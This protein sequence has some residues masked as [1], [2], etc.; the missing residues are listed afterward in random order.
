MKSF[1]MRALLVSTLIIAATGC[2]KDKGGK[3]S[4]ANPGIYP[5]S[6]NLPQTDAE[7]LASV[8]A[9]YNSSNEGPFGTPGFGP[10][11]NQ[12]KRVVTIYSQNGGCS[13]RPIKIFGTQIAT[14]QSCNSSNSIESQN[15]VTNSVVMIPNGGSK[16]GVARLATLF[17][18]SLGSITKVTPQNSQ[19]GVIY[20][21]EVSPDVNNAAVKKIYVIDTGANSALNPVYIMDTATRTE[22]SLQQIL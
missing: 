11:Y 21:L 4:A 1:I 6:Y 5:Y 8:T 7:A 19:N 20:T 22:D 12:E 9:W 10:T 17:N 3:G 16:A 15:T 18:G 2:G 13:T 14:F